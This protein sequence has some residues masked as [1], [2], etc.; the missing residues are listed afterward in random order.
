MRKT[1]RYPIAVAAIAAVLSVPAV[2]AHAG[3][4]IVPRPVCRDLAQSKFDIDSYGHVSWKA[5]HGPATSLDD[6]GDPGETSHYFLCAWDERGLLIAA[7]IPPATEC[8]GGSCWCEDDSS[9]RYK[10]KTGNNG[11]LRSL[12]LTSSDKVGARINAETL[13]IGGINLPVNGD[14]LVQ[15]SRSDSDVCFESLVPADGFSS[16]SSVSASG[17]SV[18]GDKPDN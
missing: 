4:S 12:Q 11:D 5:S 14:V 3:C 16:N 18:A 6:F 10:D 15:L 17:K 13:V 1:R 2:S 9:L 7:D 8:P